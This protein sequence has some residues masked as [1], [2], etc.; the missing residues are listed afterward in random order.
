M[1][2]LR[3]YFSKPEMDEEGQKI[4]TIETTGKL[5]K[6]DIK[7]MVPPLIDQ[8]PKAS[9]STIRFRVYSTKPA[10]FTS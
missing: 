9:E 6:S 2:I 3:N 10:L 7:S 8:Y 4:A 5:I 1:G